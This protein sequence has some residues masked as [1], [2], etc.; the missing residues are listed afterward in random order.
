[1]EDEAQGGIF[2]WSL[3]ETA[4]YA[5]TAVVALF[6]LDPAALCRALRPSVGVCLRLTAK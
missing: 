6:G 5:D 1:M 4:L 3:P 2:T